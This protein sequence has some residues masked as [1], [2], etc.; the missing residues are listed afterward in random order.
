[1]KLT[2]SK[3]RKIIR[4]ELVKEGVMNSSQYADEGLRA[5]QNGNREKFIDELTNL[6]HAAGSLAMSDSETKK[7]FDDINRMMHDI[8]DLK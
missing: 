2:E 7:Y 5:Y 4:E 3:L 1:M 8:Y 6:L